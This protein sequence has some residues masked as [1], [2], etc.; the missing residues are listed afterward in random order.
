M[1]GIWVAATV[2]VILLHLPA[3]LI[4]LTLG[5]CAL[6]W[7]VHVARTVRGNRN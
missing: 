2:L 4:K 7:A 6:V 3:Y 5:L 1:I